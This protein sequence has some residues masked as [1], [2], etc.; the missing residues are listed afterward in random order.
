MRRLGRKRRTSQ[1]ALGSAAAPCLRLAVVR[2]SNGNVST[3]RPGGIVHSR[4]GLV[5]SVASSKYSPTAGGAWS[6]LS[7]LTGRA[8]QADR[9]ASV[10]RPVPSRFVPSGRVTCGVPRGPRRAA[11]IRSWGSRRPVST[12]PVI[13]SRTPQ[14]RSPSRPSGVKFPTSRRSP[15]KDFTG[16]RQSSLTTPMSRHLHHGRRRLVGQHER[17]RLVCQVLDLE[18]RE[19]GLVEPAAVVVLGVGVPAPAAGEHLQRED[20]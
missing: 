10:P 12:F 8:S 13:A 11:A 6:A 1:T 19:T 17:L 4:T 16:C 3:N 14:A 18:A 15:W 7:R 2:I 9:E 20:G 5:S